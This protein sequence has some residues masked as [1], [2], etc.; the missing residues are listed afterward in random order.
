MSFHGKQ[1]EVAPAAAKEDC[2]HRPSQGTSGDA[3]WQVNNALLL[4]EEPGHMITHNLD[5][6]TTVR[7]LASGAGRAH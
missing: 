5:V 4:Q 2:E 1:E 3:E 6:R 7:K